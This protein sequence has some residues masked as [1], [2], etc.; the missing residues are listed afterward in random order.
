MPMDLQE[1]YHRHLH[2]M[3]FFF[4]QRCHNLVISQSCN[5]IYCIPTHIQVLLTYVQ[6][7]HFKM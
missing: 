1:E 5:L 6:K 7:Y 2:V 4:I 3:N